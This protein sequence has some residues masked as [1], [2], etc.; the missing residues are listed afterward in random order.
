MA[1]H[2]GHAAHEHHW[3][4]SYY[5][6]ILVAGIFFS[7]PI[8]F[9]MFFQY[10]NGTASAIALGIGVPL[11]IWGCA[12]WMG[13]GLDNAENEPGFALTGLPV[14]IIS[15][16]MLFLALF[17]AYWMLRLTADVWPPPGSP[18]IGIGLPIIM[19]IILVSSS[20]TYHMGEMRLEEGDKGGFTNW[21]VITIILG[22]TFLGCTIYEYNHLIHEGFVFSTNAKSTVFYSITGFHASHVVIGL[23]LFIFQLIPAF[24]GRISHTYATA[25]GIYWHFVD[26]VWFFV[27]SQVYFW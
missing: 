22:V 8:A 9:A 7:I 4:W 25:S 26:I 23:A 3:E 14:F 11:L 21:L 13:E 12:G 19:T 20:L 27:V 15:E 6:L 17:T 5:P 10:E 18:H 16:V 24:S 1:N 2:E